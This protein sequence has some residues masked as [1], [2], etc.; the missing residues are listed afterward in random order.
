MVADYLDTPAGGVPYF[1]SVP[2]PQSARTRIVSLSTDRTRIRA[3]LETDRP[4]AAYALGDLAPGL[5]AHCDWH[6]GSGP[7]PALVLL[8]RHHTTPVLF[9]LGGPEALEPLL[10]ETNEPEV[11]LSAREE[12]MPLIR[13]EHA[14]RE[15]AAMWRM[16][17]DPERLPTASTAHRR[18]GRE[19]VPAIGRLLDDGR[20]SG[21]APDFLR[22]TMVLDGVFYGVYDG[23]DL[24]AM[25]G[26]HVVNPEDGVAAVGNVY[27]RR[28]RR[29]RGLAG[30]VTAAVSAELVSLGC[31]TVVLNV[32]QD[33]EPAIR[34][35][36]RIGYRKYCP[37]KE[38][39]ALR[40]A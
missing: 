15:E 2:A 40:V 20:E 9:T 32:K 8:Y 30:S 16:L 33:N 19:D 10:A 24:V 3:I 38:G 1:T 21:E 34:A 17:L 13:R 28:D 26:S 18:L 29:G 11:L 4:W 35:Y 14:V 5:F 22:L 39:V 31:I 36:E 27:T 12:I 7:E 25:A 6:V 37:F 23:P